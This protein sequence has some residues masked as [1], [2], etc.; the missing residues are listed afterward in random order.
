MVEV[1]RSSREPPINE[2]MPLPAYPGPGP[3]HTRGLLEAGPGAEPGLYGD[4]GCRGELEAHGWLC[5]RGGWERAENRLPPLPPPELSR[6]VPKSI[7]FVFR[8]GEEPNLYL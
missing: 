6:L 8:G 4:P 1:G 7:I 5:Q 3:A 2:G